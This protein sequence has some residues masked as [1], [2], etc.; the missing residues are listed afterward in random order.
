MKSIVL[1]LSFLAVAWCTPKG[2]HGELHQNNT[3]GPE[4]EKTMTYGTAITHYV[5][6]PM[7]FTDAEMYCRRHGTN[8]HLV[9]I[10]DAKLNKLVLHLVK[11]TRGKSPHSTWIGGMRFLKT[12]NFIW[13]DGSKWDYNSWLPGEPNNLQQK[14][15][16]S[17]MYTAD[18]KP[19]LWNDADCTKK[20]PFVCF[21]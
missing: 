8:G 2:L 1:L 19:G 13:T 5:S 11:H 14:E 17:E 12:E 15:L 21:Y 20:N 16:C 9:S 10:H 4:I 3:N 7:A 18:Y 6:T